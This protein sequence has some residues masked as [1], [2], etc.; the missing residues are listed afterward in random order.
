[1]NPAEQSRELYIVE[2]DSAATAVERVCN[3]DFQAVL[4]MQGKPLNAWKASRARVAN[5]ELYSQLLN[6][7]GESLG[8]SSFPKPCPFDRVHLLFDPDADGIHCSVLML[9]F[10]YRWLPHWLESGRIFAAAAPVCELTSASAAKVWYPKDAREVERVLA[11]CT[12]QGIDDI[13]RKNFRGLASI[14]S[15]LLSRRCV[16][17]KTRQLSVLRSEDAVAALHAFGAVP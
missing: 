7:L 10:F 11:E 12:K 1:M 14:G 4:P 6:V 13:Q 2:G 17:P 9:W 8:S 5:N 15:E 3:H 16:D